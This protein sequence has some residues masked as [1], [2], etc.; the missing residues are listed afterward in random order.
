ML[1]PDI[2]LSVTLKAGGNIQISGPIQDKV[3][4]YGLLS[5]AMDAVRE[6]HAAQVAAQNGLS[7]VRGTLPPEGK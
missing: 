5:A 2:T 3:L 4:C 6:F 1:Q 7:I